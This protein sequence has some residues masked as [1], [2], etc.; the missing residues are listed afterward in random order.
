MR[1]FPTS[2]LLTLPLALVALALACGDSDD[3]TTGT[4]T[5][6]DTTAGS[7][8]TETTSPTTVMPLSAWRDHMDSVGQIVPCGAVRVVDG[9]Q[10]DAHVLDLAAG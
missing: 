10:R 3:V 9:R 6:A 1:R 2:R 7:E 8:T 5:D 4:G